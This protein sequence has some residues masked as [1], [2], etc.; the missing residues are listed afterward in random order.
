MVSE[1]KGDEEVTDHHRFEGEGENQNSD[2]I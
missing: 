1:R 2:P